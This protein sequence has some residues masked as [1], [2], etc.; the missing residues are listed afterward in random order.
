MSPAAKAKPT[1]TRCPHC[2]QRFGSDTSL[3]A[4][5]NDHRA[6]YI[7]E[8]VKPEHLAVLHPDR[9]HAELKKILKRAGHG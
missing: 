4:H 1:F 5:V 6:K 2:P 8:L 3:Q 9:H 7:Q